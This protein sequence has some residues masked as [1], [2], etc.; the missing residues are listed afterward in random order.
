[1]HIR[2]NKMAAS[3]KAQK[4]GLAA[5]ILCVSVGTV[6]ADERYPA[7][8]ANQYYGP[9]ENNGPFVKPIPGLAPSREDRN[10]FNRSGTRGR[11]GLGSGHESALYAPFTRTKTEFNEKINA[12]GAAAAR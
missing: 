11:E 10:A 4:F 6:A 5:V 7:S 9:Y 8:P 2:I 1:M 3:H 12:G